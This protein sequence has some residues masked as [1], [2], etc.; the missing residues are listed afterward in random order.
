ME[1][2]EKIEIQRRKIEAGNPSI[3]LVDSCRIDEGIKQLSLSELKTS[4]EHFDQQKQDLDL[5]FFVPA[6]GSGSRMFKAF[7]DYLSLDHSQN[8]NSAS[9][10]LSQI[11]QLGIS[12]LLSPDMA[13]LLAEKAA[14]ST[15]II[16]KTFVDKDQLNLSALPKG[17][18]PFHIYDNRTLNPFQ[19]HLLHSAEVGNSNSKIHFTIDKKFEQQISNKIVGICD[20]LNT[21][22]SQQ[23]PLTNSI[24]FTN[25]LE[26][27]KENNEIISR[28]AGHGTLINNL[29]KLNA[30]VIFIRNIDNLQH[31]SKSNKSVLTRKALAN[32]LLNFKNEAHNVLS[33]IARDHAFESSIKTLND[34]YNLELN[35]FELTS[36]NTAFDALNRPIR[37][38]GMVKNEGEPG[39]G[40]FWVK[41][42]AGKVSR[43]I[44]EKA[45]ISNDEAQLKLV[46]KS[47]HFNP[48]ELVCSVKSFDNH[49]FDLLDFV[50]HDQYF[51]VSKSQAGQDI[52]YIEQPGLWNGAM[53]NWLTLFYEIDADCFSPVKSVFDLLKAPHRS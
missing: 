7:F 18:I 52:K 44:V 31:Q 1:L 4:A 13:K 49:K 27:A 22:F 2:K 53:A 36:P 8:N 9:D 23:D 29:N 10:L 46:E 25:D 33:K 11:E 39:G 47:T 41:D 16:V 40:P 32:E 50:N 12:N 14:N 5:C 37:I 15:E 17:L 34:K 45:Q 51:I 30:D 6:S 24:A 35:D 38:C 20:S 19:E 3:E 28:P 43:Q 26:P 21:S 48:V 42:N